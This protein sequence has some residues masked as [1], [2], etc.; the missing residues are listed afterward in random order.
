MLLSRRPRTTIFP[1]VFS[2]IY[3]LKF[4]FNLHSL[5]SKCWT[6]ASTNQL[7]LGSCQR[8][9][10]YGTE[11]RQTLSFSLTLFTCSLSLTFTLNLLLSPSY[12]F[13]SFTLSLSLTLFLTHT[14]SLTLSL[15]LLFSL[16]FF[17]KKKIYIFFH[18]RS[19][20]SI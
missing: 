6:W 8:S 20:L 15:S 5:T 12:S 18:G 9:W 17:F 1:E 10:N 16:T 4:I 19:K 3:K 2:P 13:C 11:K 7:V 14:L